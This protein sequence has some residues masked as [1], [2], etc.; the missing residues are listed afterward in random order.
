MIFFRT[1]KYKF[2]PDFYL[3]VRKPAWLTLAFFRTFR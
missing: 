2:L 1:F 3:K